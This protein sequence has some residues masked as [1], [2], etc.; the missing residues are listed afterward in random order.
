MRLSQILNTVRY[1]RASTDPYFSY[2]SQ[3]PTFFDKFPTLSLLFW[4]MVEKYILTSNIVPNASNPNL[5]RGWQGS[6]LKTG[7]YLHANRCHAITRC[8]PPDHLYGKQSEMVTDYARE[9]MLRASG[10][11][12]IFPILFQNLPSFPCFLPY[13]LGLPVSTFPLLVAGKP[14]EALHSEMPRVFFLPQHI[15]S[16]IHLLNI[17]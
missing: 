9:I 8:E 14:A 17:L 3:S 15:C 16:F 12:Y 1:L 6:D 11:N 13:F 5:S 7:C 4:F 2:F 10:R